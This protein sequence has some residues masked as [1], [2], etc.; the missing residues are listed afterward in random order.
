MDL[1]A[2][3]SELD[4]GHP[5]TGAYSA[6]DSTA[7][8]QLLAVNRTAPR[9]VNMTQLREWAAVNARAFKINQG[10]VGGTTDQVK[11]LCLIADKLL[12]TDDGNLDPGNPAHVT[13]INEL[14]DDGILDADDRTALVTKATVAVS[15]VAEIGLGVPTPSDIANAR[16]LS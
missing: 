9:P 5:G 10:I 7:K 16:R 2:L 8:D 6:N 4:A 13:L 11:N 1:V 15:R 14:V 12:G 3:K